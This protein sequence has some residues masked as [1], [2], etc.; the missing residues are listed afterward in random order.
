MG[1]A[2]DQLK[3]VE[4]PQ[5]PLIR[6]AKI[7]V[8]RR[9]SNV[10]MVRGAMYTY[11]KESRLD[12]F[13]ICETY[14]DGFWRQVKHHH[15]VIE[16]EDKLETYYPFQ[17]EPET[18]YRIRGFFMVN[19][20]VKGKDRPT[21]RVLVQALGIWNIWGRD[22]GYDEPRT[23]PLDLFYDNIPLPDISERI[24]QRNDKVE[25]VEEYRPPLGWQQSGPVPNMFHRDITDEELQERI[26]IYKETHKR[27]R[28][29]KAEITQEKKEE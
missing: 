23:T 21:Q 9:L 13:L 25:I 18:F 22:D 15:I 8:T 16:N 24:Y 1:G 14:D 4:N 27:K 26:R 2:I 11:E 17:C 10:V 19:N 12:A 28:R 7:V 29:K 5:G 6:Q 20:N 3:A